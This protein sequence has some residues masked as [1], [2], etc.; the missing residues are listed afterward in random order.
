VLIWHLV[1]QLE[2][3]DIDQKPNTRGQFRIHH[4]N[5]CQITFAFL[6]DKVKFVG[7][8]PEGMNMDAM[9]CKSP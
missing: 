8:G 3:K 9:R 5:N 1:S 7:I 2:G 6:K 4:V